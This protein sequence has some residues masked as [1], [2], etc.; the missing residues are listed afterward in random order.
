MKKARSDQ[1]IQKPVFFRVDVSVSFN[2]QV[3]PNTYATEQKVPTFFF[4][5]IFHT[6][7]AILSNFATNW[8]IERFEKY[9]HK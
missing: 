8:I 2:F 4:A 1:V 6:R 9:N 5:A 7:D 3:K